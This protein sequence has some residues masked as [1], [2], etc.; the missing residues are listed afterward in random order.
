M[1][2]TPTSEFIINITEMNGNKMTLASIPEIMYG[3]RRP[4]LVLVLSDKVP[5]I[6]NIKIANKLS[7]AIMTPTI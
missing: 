1:T 3:M 6:G 7:A 5:K 2:M 4:H